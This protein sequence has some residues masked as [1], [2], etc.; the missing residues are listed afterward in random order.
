MRQER[1]FD[2]RFVAQWNETARQDGGH[3]FI[4]MMCL[5]VLM[6]YLTIGR[7]HP[8]AYIKLVWLT[9]I[10]ACLF[11]GTPALISITAFVRMV[12]RK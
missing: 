11:L 12:R 10:L 8:A 2:R 9:E 7:V 4:V 5:S 6:T 3:I 1:G